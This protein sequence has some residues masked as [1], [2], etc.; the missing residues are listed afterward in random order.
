MRI[1]AQHGGAKGRRQLDR[2]PGGRLPTE[3][4]WGT[5]AAMA[6]ASE[7]PAARPRP[8]PAAPP[9]LVVSGAPLEGTWAGAPRDAGFA[10]LAGEYAHGFLGRRL[11]EKRWQALFLATP[12]AMISFAIVDGGYL[13][14]GILSVF[15]RGARRVL[16]DSNPVLPPLFAFVAE[17]PNDGMRAVFTGPRIGARIE[18][19]GGRILATARWGNAAIDLA[20]DARSAPPAMTSSSRL[21]PGRFNFTQKLV[22]LAA[23]G[24]IRIGN[25]RFAARGEPA[26]LDFTHGYLARDT[27]WRWAFASARQGGRLIGFNLS[28]GFMDSGTG[29]NALWVDGAPC[30]VGPVRFDF[31][32]SAPLAPW[33]IRAADGSLDLTFQPEGYRS[34][35]VDLKLVVSKYLQP[36]GVFSGQVTTVSG[37]RLVL[38][39]LPGVTE[40]HTARW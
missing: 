25:A 24:E 38:D 40:D 13:S 1:A 15:D 9:R 17:E 37:E 16:I 26:G 27:S 30:S 8:L 29:E 2:W 18:R 20:L 35:N 11:V 7:T 23:E 10:G 14:S 33:R 4:R 31:E 6:E 32:P 39:S 19:S 21:G 22:G 36:F 12:Q 5:V 34:Q 28:E 3:R